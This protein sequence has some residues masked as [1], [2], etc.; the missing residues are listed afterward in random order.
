MKAWVLLGLVFVTAWPMPTPA[1]RTTDAA[2]PASR[3]LRRRWLEVP[4]PVAGGGGV[5]QAGVPGSV[6]GGPPNE[7]AGAAPSI[8]LPARAPM[9]YVP[10][11]GVEAVGGAASCAVPI[12]G[13]SGCWGKV[14]ECSD[15]AGVTAGRAMAASLVVS[16]APVGAVS[17]SGPLTGPSVALSF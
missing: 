2:A 11:G 10:W 13:V 16:G 12:G 8:G 4:A 7:D 9:A 14:K 5:A 3:P 6:G 17:G 1:P 15:G